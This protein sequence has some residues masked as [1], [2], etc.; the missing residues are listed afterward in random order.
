LSLARSRLP[1][2]YLS[3]ILEPRLKHV[4]RAT[5]GVCIHESAKRR[6]G[7]T[8]DLM[9]RETR[10]LTWEFIVK[11]DGMTKSERPEI[12]VVVL[13]PAEGGIYHNGSPG[14]DGILNGILSHS[15]VMMTTNPTVLDALAL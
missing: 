6:F 1:F 4:D 10:S 2:G 9:R 15:I 13:G 8:P 12:T 5:P 3:S 7:P 11:G 14:A